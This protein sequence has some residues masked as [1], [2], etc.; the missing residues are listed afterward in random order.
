MALH[1]LLPCNCGQKI[2]VAE[3]LAETYVT[4]ACGRSV[5]VPPRNQL[6]KLQLDLAPVPRTEPPQKPGE[7]AAQPSAPVAAPVTSGDADQPLIAEVVADACAKCGA[8]LPAGARFC[9]LCGEKHVAAAAAAGQPVPAKPASSAPHSS[10]QRLVVWLVIVVA[11]VVGY[12][13]L[14]AQDATLAAFYLLAVVP[15][16]IVVFV[17]S[18][19]ARQRGEPW[20]PA[21]TATVAVSTAAGT[22]MTV[23]T[24]IVVAAAIAAVTAV[25]SIIALFAVCAA[26]LAGGS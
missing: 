3:T 1:Y 22:V 26:L 2:S 13:V 21:K 6:Y 11:A 23:L 8:V 12:G 17:G 20:T 14:I 10:D 19:T 15:A 5:R 25:A 18:M 9:W 7:P 24:V 4:C 16:L